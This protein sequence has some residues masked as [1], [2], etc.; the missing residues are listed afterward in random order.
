MAPDPNRSCAACPS[1][2]QA[3]EVGS[4]FKKQIGAPMCARFGRVLGKVNTTPQQADKLYRY[5]AKD[6]DGFGK[7]RPPVPPPAH[8]WELTVA[9]ADPDAREIRDDD[10]PLK[11]R[12]TSCAMCVNRVTDEA[13]AEE[14]GWTA[15][16]C[17][18]KGRLIFANRQVEEAKGCDFRAYGPPRGSTGGIHLMPEYEDAFNASVDPIRSYFKDKDNFVDPTE[19]TSD[20]EVTESEKA[21]G[22]RAWRE[23]HD[24]EGTGNVVLIPVYEN[25]YFSP[26]ELKKIP[27]TG[28]DAHPELYIDHCNAVYTV[29]VAWMKLDETPALWGVAGTGKTELY[30][31][32]AW[33][34]QLPFERISIT[35]ETELDDIEGKMLFKPDVGTYPF[36]G[37]LPQA[38]SKPCV[39]CIDEPNTG[40]PAVWQFLRPLTDNAKQLILD[41]L[42]GENMD[43]HD[44]C[45]MGMAM[46]PAWDA[47]NVG[48][49]ELGDADGSRLMHIFIPMPPPALER[50]I[51]RARVKLDGWEISDQQL[52]MMMNIA[53]ELRELSED[54]LTITWGV[55]NQIKV[56]R[57]LRWF[58]PITAY[59]RGAADYLEP[60]QQEAM[61]DIV[62]AHATGPF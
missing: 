31:H 42:E 5:F 45:Y 55:R 57:A 11:Q 21:H 32:I 8:Q 50:E 20:A 25:G 7:A 26:E 1:F 27:K 56:G 58:D 28:E 39:I 29:A 47:R 30:R 59:R 18:S 9:L 38:W 35:E 4:K 17:A 62:R 52:D 51:I 49:S 60:Q 36:Y 10:D 16:L 54:T 6:C 34:M 37:R 33:L 44:D 48:T 61:L 22:I 3:D 24:Q 23:V 2:L 13:V 41:A 53:S 43:R 15:S 19:Y 46:N 14:L 40:Q 12:C